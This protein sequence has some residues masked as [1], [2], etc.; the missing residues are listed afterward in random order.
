MEKVIVIVG[1]TCSGKTKLS[2]LLAKL[3]NVEI[4]SA[5]SRQIYKKM[6]IGTAKPSF[7]DLSN[8]KHYFI[9][10]LEPNED[11]NASK[12]EQKADEI[13]KKILLGNKIPIV[14]GGSGLYI[15]ALIDGI[16]ESIESSS[17]LRRELLDIRNKY[18]NEY[19]YNEL[20]KIDPESSKKMLP[21]NWKRVL[22][23]LEVFKLTGKPIWQHYSQQ[24]NKEVF[25][26]HQIGLLWDRNVLYKNIENRVDE[27]FSNGL[28]T[29]VN[30]ILSESHSKNINSLNT[31]GYKE[32]IDYF[33]GNISLH[34]AIE[35]VKR[36]TR[37]YAK[38][39]MT[40]FNAD[41]R[42]KWYPINGSRDLELLANNI[43]KEINER[44][45]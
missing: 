41:K 27:M 17:V 4:I 28:I 34:R 25:Q 16:S 30:K 36:N 43:V 38:R 39:Q 29:E 22:R 6:N 33:D 12:F 8:V 21:Q 19:L 15:K 9:D 18:G 14:V 40:W 2:L 37:R 10:E 20:K 3:L 44:K 45:N 13:I 5:D 35:L 11:F 23:A 32:V 7:E 1:P 26:F 31:V 24:K 42:I